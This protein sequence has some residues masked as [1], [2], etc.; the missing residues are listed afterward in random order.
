MSAISMYV[1][2]LWSCLVVHLRH[3]QGLLRGRQLLAFAPFSASQL[4]PHVRRE[5]PEGAQEA[6]GRDQGGSQSLGVEVSTPGH[7][8]DSALVEMCVRGLR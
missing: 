6:T 4:Q 3:L 1:C 7:L 5:A 2:H 8:L